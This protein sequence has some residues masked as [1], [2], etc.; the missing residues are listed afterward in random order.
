VAVMKKQREVAP[1]KL[2]PRRQR[3]L[4]YDLECARSALIN[5]RKYL[6]LWGL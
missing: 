6:K 3:W 4:K 1:P 5:L 2:I